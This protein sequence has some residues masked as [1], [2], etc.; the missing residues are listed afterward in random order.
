M[1]LPGQN[2]AAARKSQ[3]R[4]CTISQWKLVMKHDAWPV[5]WRIADVQ[6]EHI[7]TLFQGHHRTFVRSSQ[8][9]AAAQT[10]DRFTRW[11][12][13][14]I[15]LPCLEDEFERSC[16][17]Q[18][19]RHPDERVSGYPYFLS[20]TWV[21]PTTSNRK[22]IFEDIHESVNRSEFARR[23]L[24]IAKRYQFHDAYPPEIFGCLDTIHARGAGTDRDRMQL[25]IVYCGIHQQNHK[26]CR[27]SHIC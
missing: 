3:A 23:K 14:N 19:Q 8:G 20:G 11:Q 6:I 5:D 13:N 26:F 16:E 12:G 2:D 9:L 1:A 15:T 18:T 25:L 17:Q 4:L 7:R 27:S 10:R 24:G 21:I 22:S